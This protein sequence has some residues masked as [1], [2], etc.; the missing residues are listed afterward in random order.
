[1]VKLCT[2]TT[3]T[4][5]GKCTNGKEF[6]NVFSDR[7]KCIPCTKCLTL[8]EKAKV[9]AEIS[10]VIWMRRELRYLW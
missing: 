8:D 9:R 1:M 10:V 6:S 3:D 5:C 4:E 7:D 2:N